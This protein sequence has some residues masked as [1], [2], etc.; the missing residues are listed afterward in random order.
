MFGLSRDK[1]LLVYGLGGSGRAVIDKLGEA[2]FDL[3]IY[4]DKPETLPADLRERWVVAKVDENSAA[5]GIDWSRVQA[6]VKT[7]GIAPER[8]LV[9]AALAAAVPV[10]GEVDLFWR[11][12][13]DS[14]AVMLGITGTNGK[15]TTTALIAHILKHAGH[16]VAAGGNLGTPLL[17]L[18]EL[19]AGGFYVIEFSSYQLDLMREMRVDGAVFLNLTPD[20]LVRHHTMEAYRDVKLKLFDLAKG[21]AV[22]VMGIDQPI[23][24]DWLARDGGRHGR[25]ASVSVGGEADYRVRDAAVWKAGKKLIDIDFANLRGPH[26]A[27]NVACALA[28]LVPRWVTLEQFVSGAASFMGLP[29]RLENVGRVEGVAFVNDSKATNGDSAVYALQSFDSI[30]W[31]CGGDPKSDGL[32]DTVHHLEHVRAAF[33]IGACGDA[34]ADELGRRGVPVFRCGVLERAVTEAFAAARTEGLDGAVV[35]LSPAAASLDQFRSFEHRGDVF[36]NCVRALAS[37][38]QGVVNEERGGKVPEVNA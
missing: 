10:L 32:G 7:P 34:F 29:H 14:G 12:E 24:H 13:K 19:E 6:L 37:Q 26:N 17:Y 22:R 36:V 3:W 23:L 16:T 15:S 1:P 30:Y 2:G 25:I 5:C 20:H 11:R 4:D 35:L 33:T 28:L 21:D 31:I 18:P 9:Q 8:P 27:Q 38:E